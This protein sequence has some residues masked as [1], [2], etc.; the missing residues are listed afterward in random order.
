MTMTQRTEVRPADLNLPRTVPLYL[1]A[2]RVSDADFNQIDESRSACRK[3]L[4]VC[5]GA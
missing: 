2:G 5:N 4:P 3:R 1:E